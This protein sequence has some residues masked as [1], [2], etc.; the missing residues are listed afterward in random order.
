MY[1][2][3][4]AQTAPDRPAVIMGTS[5][6]VVTYRELN[7]RSNQLSQVLWERGLGR[8]PAEPLAEELEGLLM[9]YSSGTTGRPKGIKH[10]FTPTPAGTAAGSGAIGLIFGF[11]DQSIYLS[12]A[13]LYHSAPLAFTTGV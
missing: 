8:P 1:P 3:T 4:H 5:G 10:N 13:P 2:G 9:L 7:D 11:N 12:P 6:E